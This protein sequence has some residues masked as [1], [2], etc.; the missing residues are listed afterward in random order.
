MKIY[1]MSETQFSLKKG[2]EK[3]KLSNYFRSTDTSYLN[4]H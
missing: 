3:E 4:V 2:E 1:L